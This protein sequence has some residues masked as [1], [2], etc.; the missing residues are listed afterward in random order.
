MG[1]KPSFTKEDLKNLHLLIDYILEQENMLLDK[2]R[3]NS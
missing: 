3:T 1:S 2:K